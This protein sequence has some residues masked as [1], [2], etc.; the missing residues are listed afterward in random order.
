MCMLHALLFCNFFAVTMCSDLVT[1][2]IS[3]RYCLKMKISV[4]YFYFVIV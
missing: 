1:V 2:F 4:D 3:N